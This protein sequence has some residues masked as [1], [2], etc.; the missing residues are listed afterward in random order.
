METLHLQNKI[1]SYVRLQNVMR[2][3]ERVL[4]EHRRKGLSPPELL[5]HPDD[6]VLNAA[7]GEA[8]I[9]GPKTP[10]DLR[11]REHTMELRN[12]LILRSVHAEH[13]RRKATGRTERK[14]T[15]N[16]LVLAHLLDRSLPQRFRWQ[17]D[18]G[19]NLMMEYGRHS[20]QEREKRITEEF[21]HLQATKTRPAWV[22]P[23][24]EWKI[25]RIASRWSKMR[26]HVVS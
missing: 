8:Q 6:I 10:E 12:Y 13:C 9:N 25:D 23:E 22:T 1:D 7:T 4:A 18:A 2:H 21:G 16:F 14:G 5:P 20:K 24:I 15:C 26:K 17:E 3:G 19:L 11:E